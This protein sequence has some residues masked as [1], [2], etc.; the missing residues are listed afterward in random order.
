[1]QNL[2]Q[3]KEVSEILEVTSSIIKDLGSEL[4]KEVRD[5]VKQEIC[6]HFLQKNY[7]NAPMTI[8]SD[9]IYNLICRICNQNCN[10]AIHIASHPMH[11]PI[12]MLCELA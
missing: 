11:D 6:L 4:P 5:D 12:A 2:Y 7:Y 9:E 1:M 8:S 10:G 3:C